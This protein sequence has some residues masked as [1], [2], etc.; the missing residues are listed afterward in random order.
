MRLK[1]IWDVAA[2]E[3]LSTVRDQRAIIS[4]LVLPLVLL[5][6]IMLGMP[7]LLGGLFER[8]A[9]SVTQVAVRGASE[10]PTG[11][12]SAI[13][14][15]NVELV[16]VEDP[17]AAVRED[18][19]AVGIVVPEGFGEAVTTG[20]SADLT[21]L[22][23][24]GNM[25][26]ELNASK[27]QEAV[28]SYQQTVVAERLGAAGLDPA[29]LQPV[30]VQRVDASS[31]AERSSGQLSW[32]IP[33]FIAIWTLTGGQMTA[34]DATAGEKERGTLESLLVAPVRRTEVV[35]GKFIATM[36]FGLGAALAAI[37]GYLVGGVALRSVFLPRLGEDAE[38][39]V[40]VMGGSL[41][42]DAGSI[43]LLLISAVLLAAVVSAVLIGICMFARSF[44]EAQSYVAPL[45]F[46]FVIP[47]VGLQFK[48]LIGLGDSAYYI[49]VF[50]ALLVM[51]DIVKG[52]VTAQHMLMTW[53]SL[54]VVIFV[55]LLFAY[56]N[57]NREDV[58]FRS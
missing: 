28:V 23:K 14:A 7:L 24:L 34:I 18:E 10:L 53:G 2:K 29:I 44:K 48:D 4:N 13:E 1:Q 52:D 22:A 6:V 49:P 20:G 12:R 57:F 5:P 37:A 30:S 11:L 43:V 9:V 19:Y 45:S 39:L 27:V 32:L 54:I 46:L 38:E 15:R 58:I 35:A 40:S 42:V 56:R 31:A 17:E 50:N 33:F 3:I 51:D 26:S 8:E 25:R 36:V 16:E 21:L 47:A 41:A 55:L